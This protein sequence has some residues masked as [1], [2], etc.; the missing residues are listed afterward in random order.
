MQLEKDI[1][2]YLKNEIEKR[3]GLCWKFTSPGT[4]GVPDR[5]IVIKD[6]VIFT[7]LKRP[8]GRLSAIQKVRIEELKKRG[9][10]VEVLYDKNDVDRLLFILDDAS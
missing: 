5:I 1:E 9:A 8:Q 10:W 7:E 4:A 3:K 6:H 2:K